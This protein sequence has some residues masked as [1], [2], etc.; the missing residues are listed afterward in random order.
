MGPELA[1]MLAGTAMQMQAAKEQRDDRRSMLNRQLERDDAATTKAIDLVQDESGQY[2]VP[3]RQQAM[4][5]QE[6][7]TY[8]QIQA[9][10]EGA[11]GANVNTA[12]DAGAVSEDFIKSKAARAVDEGNRLTAVA[13]EAAKSRA[14]GQLMSEDAMRR[15]GMA[16]N[17]QNLWG[18]NKNMGRATGIDAEG[19]QAPAY[20]ALGALASAAGQGMALGKTKYSGSSSNPFAANYENQMDRGAGINFGPR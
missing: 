16:G 17:L 15:A 11:G 3:N 4:Q 18:T 5:E 8:D 12:S 19:V 1:L 7:K 13:R 10:M 20:G 2:T 6:Q 14:P 9:D